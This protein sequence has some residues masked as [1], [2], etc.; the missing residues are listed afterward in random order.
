M[1]ALLSIRNLSVNTA[2]AKIL[3]NVSMEIGQG[4]ITAIVGGSGS[5]K[6][7]LGMAIL[8]LLPQAMSLSGGQIFLNEKDIALLSVQA[9][10][11]VRGGA[12]GM[13]FQEPLSA[14]DPL[15]TLGQQLD[16][17]LAAHTALNK[18]ERHD[19]ILETL[20]LVEIDDAPRIYKS[21]P[22]Q[23]SGG[24]CQRVM[25]A[26]AIICKPSLVIADEP[27][28]SLDVIIQAKVMKL[29]K[30]LN[31]KYGM[32]ILLITHD[33]GMAAH[34]AD[35]I[36]VMN[37][38]KIVESGIPGSIMQEPKHIYTKALIEAY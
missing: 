18:N 6:T 4:R 36:V 12:I 29:L 16:E 9:M 34:L 27:T 24:L 23:L 25:I 26:Q 28:S 10:R 38:G 14:F 17:T 37:Q 1:K 33:L 7:T 5:G 8:R 22:H 2:Q 32:S 31:K 35:D 30:K 20:T 11:E 15:F 21:Y 3:D 19:R 13:V